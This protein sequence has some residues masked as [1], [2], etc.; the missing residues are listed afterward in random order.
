VSRAQRRATRP[1]SRRTPVKPQKSGAG[2]QIPWIPIAVLFATIAVVGVVVYLV[3][4]A[5]KPAK[6]NNAKA[7]AYE[8]NKQ[9][10]A[11]GEWVDLPNVWADGTKLAHYGQ[12]SAD[13]PNTNAHVTRTVD[14]SKETSASS[15]NGLPPVGGPHWGSSGCGPE[16]ANA[17]SFCGPAPWGIASLTVPWAAETLIHNMEHGGVVVWFNTTNTAV[18]DKLEAE[19]TKRVKDGYYVVMTPYSDIPPDTIYLTSWARREKIDVASYDDATVDKFITT[20][21]CAF[22]PENFKNCGSHG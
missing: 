12:S 2:I 7:A 18:R 9:E 21:Q 3:I 5:G 22:N 20:F 1:S 16:P 11:P 4:Q 13:G 10:G 19:V 8:L 15:P 17:P 14:Y 6:P